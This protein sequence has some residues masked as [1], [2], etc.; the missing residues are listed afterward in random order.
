[1][2]NLKSNKTRM[3]GQCL[4]CFGDTGLCLTIKEYDIIYDDIFQI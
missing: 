4:I 2:S 1:M 3:T